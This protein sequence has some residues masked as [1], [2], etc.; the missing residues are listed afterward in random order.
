MTDPEV[1]RRAGA[2]LRMIRLRL[3]L[4][5]RQ[6]ER[7]SLRIVADRQNREFNLSRAWITDIEKGR[8]VPGSFKVVSLAEIYGLTI[9][10][11]HGF[12]GIQPGDITQER[13]MVPPPKTQLLPRPHRGLH[14]RGSPKTKQQLES[15]NLLT[16]LVNIWGDR[17]IP[18]LPHL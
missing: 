8:F 2:R 12:Y 17:P 13:P 3:G 4:S 9:A 18:M 14:N 6:V 16:H 1:I 15:A 7:R 5:L 11:I 10:E